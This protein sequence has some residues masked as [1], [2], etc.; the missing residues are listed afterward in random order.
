MVF[1][2]WKHY[3]VFKVEYCVVVRG[4]KQLRVQNSSE[5]PREMIHMTRSEWKR[6]LWP[7]AGDS[8]DLSVKEL[9]L[10][11]AQMHIPQFSGT[12]YLPVLFRGSLLSDVSIV[13]QAHL[14]TINKHDLQPY[15]HLK[16]H[17]IIH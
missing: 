5:T 10:F 6:E 16:N 15:D 11:P 9:K 4:V 7:N 3:N 12:L 8:F 17:S 13:A 2:V 14:S 1:G